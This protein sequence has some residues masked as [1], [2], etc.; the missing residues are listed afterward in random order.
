MTFKRYILGANHI[1]W[2]LLCL[3]STFGL[4]CWWVAEKKRKKEYAKPL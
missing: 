2:Y 3:G 1:F 4:G